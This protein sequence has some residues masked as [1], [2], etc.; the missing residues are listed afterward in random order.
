[1]PLLWKPRGLQKLCRDLGA[2]YKALNYKKTDILAI[3]EPQR[4]K[5]KYRPH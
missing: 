4:D 3:E 5:L 2:T 1:M